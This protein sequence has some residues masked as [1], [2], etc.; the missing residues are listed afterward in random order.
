MSTRIPKIAHYVWIG[1]G[2][3]GETIRRCVSSF[4]KHLPDYQLI[5]W[6]NE[7]SAEIFETYPYAKEAFEAGAFAFASDVIRLYALREY[8]GVYLDSDVELFKSLDP[9]L[10]HS[11]FTGFE[12]EKHAVTA[13]MGSE[14]GGEVVSALLEYYD[15]RHFL[16]RKGMDFTT[17]TKTIHN[18]LLARGV[19]EE[20][21]DQ[22]LSGDIAVYRSEIFCP[23]HPRRG[24]VPTSESFAMHHFSGS[25]ASFKR[26]ARQRRRMKKRLAI[27]GVTMVAAIVLYFLKN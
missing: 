7:R 4:R 24:G 25:W 23:F 10:E 21:R 16:S 8:G 19:V 27:L 3:Q 14:P 6:D 17:N 11:F 20:N 12:D 5:C 2:E 9:F 13:V 18:E 26:K 15:E 1:S 22:L